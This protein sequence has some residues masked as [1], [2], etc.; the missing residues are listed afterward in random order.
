[1]TAKVSIACYYPWVYLRSGVE[2]TILETV[3]RSRHNWT[4]YTNHYDLQG[5]FPEFTELNVVE[6]PRIS[7]DRGFA[8]VAKAAYRLLW[9]KIPL[10]RH[11]LLLVHSEGLGDFVTFRNRSKPVI[12]YCHQ[13]LLV[14]N[15]A[16]VQQKYSERN[17]HKRLL[18]G[19]AGAAFRILDRIAWKHYDHVFVTSNTIRKAVGDAGLIHPDRTEML[20]PGVDCNSIRP[21]YIQGDYFLAFSRLKWW[22]N[23]ELSINAFRE[24][25]RREGHAAR[26]RLIVAGQVDAGSGTYLNELKR[27]AQGCPQ[28]SFIVNPSAAEVSTLYKHC[29]AVMNTTLREPWGIISLEANAYGKP[30]IAVNQGGTLD[31][32]EHGVTGL[33]VP[34]TPQ[35]FAK[36][37]EALAGDP[38]LAIRMGI[39]GRK[40]AERYDWA[41]YVEHLDS[42]LDHYSR[43]EQND[44][45]LNSG[46]R[47][48]AK[49]SGGAGSYAEICR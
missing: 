22:K 33:L 17:P 47:N 3:R 12:C 43:Y 6:L 45:L 44:C 28:I 25:L 18:L 30:V 20:A 29:Y 38:A 2:R 39:A 34:P 48:R 16:S 4:I 23:I 37:L 41:S 24:A 8:N 19:L 10:E 11:D 14:A 49:S 46:P 27:L 21:S 32:Q 35:D 40:N 9:Q 26:F 7:V 1:M 31:S 5:T 42:F 36:A 15:D 13:P